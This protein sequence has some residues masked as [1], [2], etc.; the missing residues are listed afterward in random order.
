MERLVG[1]LWR[2]GAQGDEE[3]LFG[4]NDGSLGCPRSVDADTVCGYRV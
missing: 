3:V 2:S 4:R 1:T